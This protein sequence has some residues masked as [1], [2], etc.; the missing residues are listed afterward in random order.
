MAFDTPP[1]QRALAPWILASVLAH[2]LVF[3]W[4]ASQRVTPVL[5]QPEQQ[6]AIK[7][8]LWFQPVVSAPEP[9]IEPVATLPEPDVVEEAEPTEVQSPV[10]EAL[11]ERP[12]EQIEKQ[13]K[14]AETQVVSE[15]P[16]ISA[17][18]QKDEH[19]GVAIES[20]AGSL[21]RKHLSQ[22]QYQQQQQVAEQA[23]REFMQR[24][25]NPVGKIPDFS[26]TLSEDEQRLKAITKEVNCD[27][28]VNATVA[29]LMGIA[30][31]MVKCSNKPDF[32]QFID[33][34]LNKQN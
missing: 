14:E 5:P 19:T 7:A 20:A 33:K 2:L 10:P 6:P 17:G 34:R 1:L 27:S 28:T 22:W 32:Q 13:M 29:V 30:G 21:A 8:S 31:G 3:W 9:V 11:E 15:A 18:Q 26:Q 4:L 16:Q 24:Q 23:A 12:V 25:A